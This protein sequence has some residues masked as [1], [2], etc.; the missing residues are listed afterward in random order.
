MKTS[1]T[2]YTGVRV[3][4]DRGRFCGVAV[5]ADGRPLTLPDH[6]R[7]ASAYEWGYGGAA[8]GQ[9]ALA[10]I[11][12]ATGDQDLALACYTWFKWAKVAAWG[13]KW[14]ITAPEVR[15]WVAQCQR[16]RPEDDDPTPAAADEPL[17]VKGG[18]A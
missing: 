18:A 7:I 11:L 17:R 8:A 13:S 6:L 5:A 3:M 15:A 16:E 14:K 9:L 4:D 2:V 10:L 12:D 1:D